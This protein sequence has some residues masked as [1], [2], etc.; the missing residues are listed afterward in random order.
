MLYK[1]YDIT[2]STAND[3]EIS[4]HFLPVTSLTLDVKHLILLQIKSSP[5]FGST[6]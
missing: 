3:I 5:L 6:D 2:V 4:S 1:R